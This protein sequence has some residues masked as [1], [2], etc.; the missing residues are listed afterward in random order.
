MATRVAQ[1]STT[2][3]PESD[4][5][6]KITPSNST[7]QFPLGAG[8]ESVTRVNIVLDHVERKIIEA[9]RGPHGNDCQKARLECGMCE[10]EKSCGK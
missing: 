8:G 6:K 3:Q 1:F 10:E 7:K 2:S 4:T 5:A 9:A